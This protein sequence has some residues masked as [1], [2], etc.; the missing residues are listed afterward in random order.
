GLPVVSGSSLLAG[1][2][3]IV[4]LIV[5]YLAYLPPVLV[6]LVF[7][8]NHALTIYI[9][10]LSLHDALP[11]L[12]MITPGPVVI[13]VGFIGFLVGGFTGADRKSTRLNSSHRTIPYAV[14]CLKKKK[15]T[16]K[17]SG[18]LDSAK[19]VLASLGIS[20]SD[21]QQAETKV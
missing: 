4:P 7:L 11:I 18:L 17:I 12:A 19:G 3:V 6:C 10:T 16:G 15:Y 13:T 9:F 20:G 5:N 8:F 2:F 14:F 1:V 21:L